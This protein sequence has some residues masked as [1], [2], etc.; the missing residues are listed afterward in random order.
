MG[1]HDQLKAFALPEFVAVY[2]VENY[3][4]QATDIIRYAGRPDGV[5][6]EVALLKAELWYCIH[7]EMVCSLEDFFVRRT[8][9]IYFDIH[10]VV[11]WKAVIASECKTYLAWDDQKTSE[12]LDKLDT[13][14]STLHN[15]W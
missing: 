4:P 12:E 13:L 11:K 3:G 6:S 7:H 2:L 1:L 9:L 10:K 5:S 14:I 8:G 15:F